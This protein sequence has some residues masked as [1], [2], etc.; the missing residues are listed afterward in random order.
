MTSF[1][2]S[3]STPFAVRPLVDDLLLLGTK[4]G[5]AL[6]LNGLLVL[7]L[8]DVPTACDDRKATGQQKVASVT[9]THTH[10]IADRAEVFEVF[11]QYDFD[12]R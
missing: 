5:D 4:L 2:L 12:S 10:H 9:A 3:I 1:F 7:N 8:P 11:F 6:R